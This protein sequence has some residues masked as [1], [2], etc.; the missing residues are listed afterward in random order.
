MPM[1]SSLC[2]ERLNL[3]SLHWKTLVTYVTS[4][5]SLQK[6]SFSLSVDA[7]MIAENDYTFQK[8][9]N[10]FENSSTLKIINITGSNPFTG[11][12][13]CKLFSSNKA[14]KLEEI[15]VQ[16]DT[17]NN[18]L[19][20]AL[21]KFMDSNQKLRVLKIWDVTNYET[22]GWHEIFT[23]LRSHKSIEEFD[24]SFPDD[25]LTDFANVLRMNSSL[26]RLQLHSIIGTV[27]LQLILNAIAGP[28][29]SI[30]ELELNYFDDIDG[31]YDDLDELR[32]LRQQLTEMLVSSLRRNTS[33]KM[34][35]LNHED[36]HE[37]ADIDSDFEFF[38]SSF[39]HLLFDESSINATYDSNHV[40]QSIKLNFEP[41][42]DDVPV[43]L[44]SLLHLNQNPD[45]RAVAREKIL[46]THSLANAEFV[47][48][49]LQKVMSCL[50][51][52]DSQLNLS[53]LYGIIRTFPYLIQKE[54]MKRK[55]HEL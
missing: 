48:S 27:Q 46:Q 10:W 53:Q 6:L 47:T 12:A 19:M 17:R 23:A 50:G 42:R 38:W 44:Y 39:T 40:L 1:L 15:A 16:V 28:S 26:K 37:E 51:N 54:Q 9:F 22:E 21:S 33:V 45:K 25:D 11:A 8:F 7:A 35:N 43:E 4:S 3:D 20:T 41:Y 31:N 36:R 18:L 49:A 29:C 34:L 55:F 32:Q 13:W 52:T 2:L 5:N 14:S 30:E 24:A